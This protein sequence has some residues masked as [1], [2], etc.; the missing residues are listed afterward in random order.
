MHFGLKKNKTVSVRSGYIDEKIIPCT[1][2]T[3]KVT[4]ECFYNILD[5]FQ[6][7]QFILNKMKMEVIA[8]N[9]WTYVF[10]PNSIFLNAIMTYGAYIHEFYT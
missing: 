7:S 1:Y 6:N 4:V 2:N 9:F 5:E 10:L 3:F 8:F